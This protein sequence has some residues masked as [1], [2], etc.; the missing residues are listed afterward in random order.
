MTQGGD[1]DKQAEIIRDISRMVYAEVD[2]NIR[3]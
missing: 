1:F 2:T 3:Q